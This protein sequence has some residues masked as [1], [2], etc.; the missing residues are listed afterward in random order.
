MKINSEKTEGSYHKTVEQFCYENIP[1]K[2]RYIDHIF[3]EKKVNKRRADIFLEEKTGKTRKTIVIEIQNSPLKVN[4]LIKRTEDY[5]KEGIYVLWVLNGEGT[6]VASP[7]L[8]QDK[9]NVKISGLE[10]YLHGMYGGRV[11]YINNDYSTNSFELF[12][13]HFSPSDTKKYR[14]KRF[15]E[16]YTTYHIRNSHFSP[17][18][19]WNFLCKD[20]SRFKIA[21]FYDKNLTSV[22]KSKITNFI[23][24]KKRSLPSRRKLKKAILKQFKSKYGKY[25]ILHTLSTLNI[26]K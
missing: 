26:K 3:L 14:K 5:N 17:V 6:C 15:R 2:N 18:P 1:Q 16:K 9:K 13:L 20:F 24:E 8:P 23:A 10:K 12:A 7:K 22:L 25:Y 11:Y 19:V 4:E 21:R